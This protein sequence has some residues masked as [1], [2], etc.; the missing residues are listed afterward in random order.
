[1][2]KRSEL[3]EFLASKYDARELMLEKSKTAKSGIDEADMICYVAIDELKK[4]AFAQGVK[5]WI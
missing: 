4:I 2:F 1:M 5:Q 3:V